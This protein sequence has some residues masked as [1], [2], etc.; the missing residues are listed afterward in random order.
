MQIRRQSTLIRYACRSTIIIAIYIIS[1]RSLVFVA[2]KCCVTAL[3]YSA[4]FSGHGCGIALAWL[5]KFNEQLIASSE[6]G[7]AETAGNKKRN[8]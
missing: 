8:I 2:L 7:N 3:K 6:C 1:L 5:L 4:D